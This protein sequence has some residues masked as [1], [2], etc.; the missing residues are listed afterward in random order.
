MC[1]LIRR[2]YVE[3]SHGSRRIETRWHAMTP[4]R[5]PRAQHRARILACS[6]DADSPSRRRSRHA[7]AQPRNSARRYGKR[8]GAPTMME[9]TPST[10]AISRGRGLERRVQ[11]TGRVSVRLGSAAPGRPLWSLRSHWARESEEPQAARTPPLFPGPADRR[12]TSSRCAS[13]PLA[14]PWPPED[15]ATGSSI[16]ASRRAHPWPRAHGVCASAGSPASPK[17]AFLPHA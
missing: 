6:I 10:S 1:G 3:C 16:G 15:H 17:P 14:S 11:Q 12:A 5:K 9:T 2:G 7:G 8:V 4:P 13:T